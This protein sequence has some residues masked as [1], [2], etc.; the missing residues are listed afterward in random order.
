MIA[1]LSSGMRFLAPAQFVLGHRTELGLTPEQVPFLESLV[2]AQADSM[3]V[4]VQRRMSLT[5]PPSRA[6]TGFMS[7]SGPIDESA[8]REAARL[9]S[10]GQAQVLIDIAKDR[11]V[12]GAVLTADQLSMLPRLESA[13]M[14]KSMRGSRA[15]GP[16][17]AKGGVYFEFQVEKSVRQVPGTAGVEYPD[18]LRPAKVEGEVLAQFVVDTSGVYEHDTFKVLKSTHE[19]FTQAVRDALPLMRFTPAEVGGA[20]VRQLVQQPFIFALPRDQ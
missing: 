13:D 6:A 15:M 4:R 8:I 20:K 16:V 9:A 1:A 3:K 18:M 12:V 5:P 7:W 10:D 17:P 11:H 14:M 19:L 2:R